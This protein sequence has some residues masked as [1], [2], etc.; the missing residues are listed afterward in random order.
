MLSATAATLYLPRIIEVEDEPDDSVLDED[1]LKDIGATK[2]SAE[3]PE[4]ALEIFSKTRMEDSKPQVV[5]L[6]LMFPSAYNPRQGVEL[7]RL[8]RAGEAGLH[9]ATPVVVRSNAVEPAIE[10]LAREAGADDFFVKSGDPQPFLDTLTFYLGEPRRTASALCEVLS[11]DLARR[12][13]RIRIEGRDDYYAE[14]VIP[15]NLCPPEARISGGSFYLDTW[16]RYSE[17][18]AE[19]TVRARASDEESGEV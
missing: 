18:R 3:S 8:I 6:D 14:K 17:F 13:A 10:A 1:V 12:Q 16:L 9:P 11:V 19:T 5:I 7:I 4:E 2:K 15:L